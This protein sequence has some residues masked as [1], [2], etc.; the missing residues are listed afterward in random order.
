M[1]D[2]FNIFKSLE[3]SQEGMILKI[4]GVFSD[5]FTDWLNSFMTDEICEELINF[6]KG[7]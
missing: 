5:E 2:D 3:I 4:N 1:D 7:E 6:T